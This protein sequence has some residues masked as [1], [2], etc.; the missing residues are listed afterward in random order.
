MREGGRQR[1]RERAPLLSILR[2][3]RERKIILEIKIEEGK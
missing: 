1:E 2:V 3:V